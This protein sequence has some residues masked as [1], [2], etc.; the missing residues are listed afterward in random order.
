MPMM[1]GMFAVSEIIRYVVDTSPS[2]LIVD[3]KASSR[4]RATC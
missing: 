1:I 4:C 2:A 3:A